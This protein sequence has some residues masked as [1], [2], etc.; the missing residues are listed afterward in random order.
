MRNNFVKDK[1]QIKFALRVLGGLSC[2]KSNA[3]TETIIENAATVNT[4][5]QN[6]YYLK[7]KITIIEQTVTAFNLPM[8]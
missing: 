3:Q 7:R 1:S 2:C 8:K 5:S 6:D 4:I